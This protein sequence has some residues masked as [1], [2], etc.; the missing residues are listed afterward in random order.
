MSQVK[1]NYFAVLVAQESVT[2]NEAL[3]RF[4]AEVYRIQDDKLK[5]GVVTPYEPAQLRSLAVAG[6]HGA[7]A[8]ADELRGG[9]EK[10]GRHARHAWH[11]AHAAGRR[12]R[13]AR[14]ASCRTTRALIR[15]LNVH[16]LLRRAVFT[17]GQA[18]IQ[19]RLER[20]TPIPDVNFT[21]RFS[22]TLPHPRPHATRTTFNLVCHCRCGTATAA[23]S[24]R[25]PAMLSAPPKI[26]AASSTT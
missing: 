11:A 6:A 3:V 8:G 26:F 19:Q 7:R 13:D 14:P 5:V 22:G 20:V 24:C 17:Q 9:V 15:M 23:T 2:I 10:S 1:Q 21:A 18:R 12:C 4:T 16:P 25:R